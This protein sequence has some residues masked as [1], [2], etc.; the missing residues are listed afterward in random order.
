MDRIDGD[1]AAAG[2]RDLL[3]RACCAKGPRAIGVA[4]VVLDPGFR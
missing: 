2:Q 3:A 1:R 4:P